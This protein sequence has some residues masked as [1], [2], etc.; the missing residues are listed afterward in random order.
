MWYRLW[1]LGLGWVWGQGYF[2]WR[3]KQL[4]TGSEAHE[5]PTCAVQDA[6]AFYV[7]GYWY[8]RES[9]L[10]DGWLV[11]LSPTGEVLWSLRPGGAGPDRI[12]DLAVDDSLLYFCGMSGSALTHP[13]ELPPARRGDFWAGAVEK[14]TGRLRWQRRWG[15]PYLDKALSLCLTPYRTLLIVGLTWEDTTLGMQ[16]V[17]HVVQAQSGEVLQRRLWG[18]GPSFLRRI[19]P[20][21]GSSYYACIGEQDYRP[22]VGAVDYL[23]QVYWRTVF[24]FHRFP[25]QLLALHAST[26]RIFVGGRYGQAW[27]LSALDLQGRVLWE[28]TWSSSPLKGSLCVLTE[29]P[30][31]ILYALGWQYSAQAHTDGLKGGQDLWLAAVQPDGRLLWER[32]FG[33][34]QDEQGVALLAGP[35]GLLAI[36]AKLNRF[37]EAPPHQDAWLLWLRAVPCDSVPVEVRTDVPSL[38]EKAQRPI[39]FWLDLPSGYVAQRIVWDFGNGDTAEGQ[40]VTYAFSEAGTYTIQPMLSLRYGCREV[41]LRPIVLRISRP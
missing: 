2:L 11:A 37:S 39:R 17:I 4:F 23:G 33:G 25:S 40:E 32:G 19:R 20:V 12:E 21:P 16:A 30:E 1:I 7:G 26:G 13:E 3:E 14:S 6:R 29:G 8:E 5:V 31:G 36:G 22:F 28:K 15:S 41:Y 10:S 27:G 34:P 35:G 9:A 24:Q 38:R 18:K